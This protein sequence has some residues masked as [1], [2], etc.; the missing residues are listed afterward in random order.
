[1]NQDDKMDQLKGIV[2]SIKNSSGEADTQYT[3]MYEFGSNTVVTTITSDIMLNLS[4]VIEGELSMRGEDGIDRFKVT[5]AGNA[6]I[7][8]YQR[9]MSNLIKEYAPK[10]HT[11]DGFPE[12]LIDMLTINLPMIKDMAEILIRGIVSGTPISIHFHGDG[13][14]C[15]GSIAL[16][17]AI[18]MV[19]A[20]L[21]INSKNIYW[22][23]TKGIS[24]T[25][26]ISYLDE[27]IFSSY[28][29]MEKPIVLIIDFGTTIDSNNSIEKIA[30]IATTLWIDHHLI[31]DNFYADKITKYVNPWKTGGDSNL[32]AGFMTC[33]LAEM[34][35]NINFSM[36]MGASLISDH[37]S[38]APSD[39]KSRDMAIF[40]DAINIYHSFLGTL[41]PHYIESVIKDKEQ[42]IYILNEYKDQMDTAI[43]IGINSCKRYESSNGFSVYLLNFS[44]IAKMN[45]RYIK[46]GKYTS[47]FQTILEKKEPGIVSVVY[48]KKYISMRAS[49]TISKKVRFLDVIDMMK[50]DTDDIDNGGGHN[51]AAS[52]KIKGED[53]GKTASKLI[54]YLGVSRLL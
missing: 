5:L 30:K 17:K 16:Y 1:M 22:S 33:V 52:I 4:E 29:S 38:F 11:I 13:D 31:N 12:K 47:E 20:T 6:G 46:Q 49:P 41:S 10:N 44:K 34:I 8:E 15:S 36:M 54:S 21:K 27:M 9:L 51:E 26:E 35:S 42:F 45:M 19:T 28:K 32:S 24:Y 14:G 50:K 37:S 25:E 2:I 18:E 3:I 48:Y 23:A 39:D 53:I 43:S 7:R 40:L